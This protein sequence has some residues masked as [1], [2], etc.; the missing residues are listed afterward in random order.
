MDL[1][2]I[3]YHMCEHVDY[4]G[5]LCCGAEHE[6]RCRWLGTRAGS[7]AT[8]SV[9]PAVYSYNIVDGT[10]ADEELPQYVSSMNLETVQ[11]DQADAFNSLYGRI[12]LLRH[13]MIERVRLINPTMNNLDP[14]SK[15]SR[16]DWLAGSWMSVKRL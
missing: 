16:I 12:N 15:S 14:L 13:H 2:Y 7:V 11:T 10:V 6:G 9:L 5:W 1:G 3:F 8:A 4:S